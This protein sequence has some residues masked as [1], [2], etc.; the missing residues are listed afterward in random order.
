[1]NSDENM[2]KVENCL[3]LLNSYTGSEITTLEELSE[4]DVNYPFIRKIITMIQVEEED[5]DHISFEKKSKSDPNI[6]ERKEPGEKSSSGKVK[7]FFLLK[8]L[9]KEESESPMCS[10]KME[11]IGKCRS[12][13]YL[14][15]ENGFFQQANRGNSQKKESRDKRFLK[16]LFHT[17]DRNAK[18]WNI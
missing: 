1:M 11:Q 14:F 3:D 9:K 4:V 8:H 13:D 12:V 2:M 16:E 18:K 5:L 17:Y 6:Q 10:F 15:N 7:K